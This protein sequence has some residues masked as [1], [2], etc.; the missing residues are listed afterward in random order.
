[1]GGA[2]CIT[3]FLLFSHSCPL[4]LFLLQALPFHYFGCPWVQRMGRC[5]CLPGCLG[6]SICSIAS[7]IGARTPWASLKSLF[8]VQTMTG[9]YTVQKALGCNGREELFRGRS[10]LPP[11]DHP[12]RFWI[13][14]PHP[15]TID[16]TS[17]Q[18]LMAVWPALPACF[19]SVN[20]FSPILLKPFQCHNHQCSCILC[21]N[22]PL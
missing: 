4:S 5:Q 9:Q 14:D 1:M 17:Y 8:F 6:A 19:P 15:N 10:L 20:S 3:S 13:F 18:Q 21:T 2:F 22:S 16:L 12:N 11:K 7:N